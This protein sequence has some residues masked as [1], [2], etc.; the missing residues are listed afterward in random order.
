MANDSDLLKFAKEYGTLIIAVYGVIQV[1]LIAIWKKVFQKKGKIDIFETGA[2][3]IGFGAFGP[4]IAVNGT[5][6]ALKKN[7]F[8]TSIYIDLTRLRDAARHKFE[9]TAFNRLK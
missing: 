3:E 4:T 5:F 7:V 8:V 2:L 1:W 6:Q 9:W